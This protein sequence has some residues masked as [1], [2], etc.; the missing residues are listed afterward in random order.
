MAG[1]GSFC[2]YA[3]MP[4][5]SSKIYK[6]ECIYSFDTPLS[7]GGLFISLTSFWGIGENYLET[8]FNNTSEC[9]YLHHKRV[10]TLP[11]DTSED[12]PPA[13]KVTRLAIGVEGGFDADKL[14]V[15]FEDIYNIVILRRTGGTLERSVYSLTDQSIPDMI[16]MSATAV[17]T[18]SESSNQENS[19]W[20]GDVRR[21]SAQAVG[22]KQLDNGVKVA[23]GNWKCSISGCDKTDNLWMNLSCGTI[24]CG[25]KYFDGSGGNN[26]AV[27]YYDQTKYPLAVKLGT[28]TPQGGD[29]YSYVED[30]MVLDP[31]LAEHL[32]HFG[33]NMMT[34]EKS[35]KTMTEMEIE[36]NKD[37]KLEYDQIMESGKALQAVFGPNRMGLINMGNS[38]YLNSVLQVLLNCVP[39][40]TQQY[41]NTWSTSAAPSVPLPTDFSYQLGKLCNFNSS[42]LYAVNPDKLGPGQESG[43]RPGLCKA[44]I[45]Q[46]HPEF[47]SS[48]QQD[49]HELYLHLVSLLE[50]DERR[51]G[52]K[53]TNDVTFEVEERIQCNASNKVLYKT[54]R[55]CCLSVPVPLDT[56]SNFAAAKAWEDSKE[57]S[58][59]A[60][61]Y[62]LTL[63]DCL[64]SMA[65]AE[66]VLDFFSPAIN[67]KT[68]ANKSLGLKTF[69]N[70]LMLQM[71]KFTLTENWQPKKLDVLIDAPDMLD[72]A[73]LRSAGM[74]AGEE[75]MPSG[76]VEAP[77]EPDAGIVNNLMNMGFGFEAC[78][79]AA[80]HTKN[81]GVEAAMEWVLQHMDDPDLND[82][83]VIAS[84]G[85]APAACTVSPENV[86]ML[87]AMGF[88]AKQARKALSNTD[89]NLERA[90]DWVFSH[91][92]ELDEED[93]PAA[94]V[95]DLPDGAG[96]YELC[97]F[98]SHMGTSTACGHYVC[99]I[100]SG[101]DWLLYNDEKVAI[102]EEPP[103]QMAY[104]YLYRRVA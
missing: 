79:K 53:V 19:I 58:G 67:D 98:I 37:L 2:Q 99:H 13:K 36:A 12:D 22:L 77:L 68:T 28:I 85:A 24:L 62:S 94:S 46:G 14:S 20:E 1:L 93:T 81:S 30:D 97:A 89:D 49:A 48:R 41:T 51:L 47:S 11:P 92:A 52:S 104:M 91:T 87:Q 101:N 78:R 64:R 5:P 42:G 40:I 10:G 74:Q 76:P 72:I 32:S 56:A 17:L 55:D 50:K 80:Y 26:H 88:T 61:K 18:S 86:E 35:S 66:T 70:F 103:R 44:I 23:P 102:S 54:R 38:C 7:D 8:H 65:E 43:V 63:L 4:N 73:F 100:K 84:S 39:G 15:Q 60:V 82:P 31:L 57:S 34:S 75:E 25:R 95:S 3:Q 27:D 33:I 6:T 9:V 69:P 16:V 96:Q 21:E 90:A 45:G 83:L 71:R 29:V 59:E